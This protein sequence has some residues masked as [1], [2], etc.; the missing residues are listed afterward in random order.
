M[1]VNHFCTSI[2]H[3][4]QAHGVHLHGLIQFRFDSEPE[5]FVHIVFGFASDEATFGGTGFRW[6]QW[7]LLG[8]ETSPIIVFAIAS[9]DKNLLGL[10]K[11]IDKSYL[12]ECLQ[13]CH[14]LTVQYYFQH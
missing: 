13:L 3:Q 12:S 4:Y 5:P 2:I 8:F 10:T 11:I 6:H 14:E 9:W 1:P 7:Q